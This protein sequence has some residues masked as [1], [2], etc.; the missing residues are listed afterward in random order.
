MNAAALRRRSQEGMSQEQL[1]QGICLVI[2]GALGVRDVRY[3]AKKNVYVMSG[4]R[5]LTRTLSSQ[6]LVSFLHATCPKEDPWTLRSY[7]ENSDHWDGWESVLTLGM[8]C[9]GYKMAEETNIVPVPSS[10]LP[11]RSWSAAKR[12]WVAA[13]PRPQ[14]RLCDAP[15][16]Q[17]G[18]ASGPVRLEV[19][20]GVPPLFL[21]HGVSR[22]DL[23]SVE[24]CGGLLWPSWALSWR[25]P[26]TYGD[27][28]F[29]ADAMVIPQNIKPT[30]AHDKNIYVA[31]TDIW[32]PTARD[33]ERREKA[34]M[35]EQSGDYLWW[36]GEREPED[37]GWGRRGLQ[38]DLVSDLGTGD[39]VGAWADLHGDYS[40]TDRISSRRQLVRRMKRLLE[41][42]ADPEDPYAYPDRDHERPSDAPYPYAE[43]KVTGPVR[44]GD[45]PLVV[46]PRRNRALV[47]GILR[48]CEFM[49]SRLE[50]PW[51]GPLHAQAS[52]EDR[53]AFA[54]MVTEAILWWTQDPCF[55]GNVGPA[56]RVRD[57][58]KSS[59]DAT[60]QWSWARRI[61]SVWTRGFCGDMAPS[62]A[63][64]RR[65]SAPMRRA[66]QRK[67]ERPDRAAL[68][69]SSALAEIASSTDGEE[70]LQV[71]VGG[72]KLEEFPVSAAD[73]R[74]ANA[75]GWFARPVRAGDRVTMID[76]T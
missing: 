5:A 51:E 74:I 18:S 56:L 23:R 17:F 64:I 50:I 16:V 42:Y 57:S 44:L 49:G 39:I 27:V 11:F 71:L 32:S 61:R 38:N 6:R 76:R 65:M 47:D 9:L 45:I 30:G 63:Q 28:V 7:L 59:Y 68:E 29:V 67:L 25:V 14:V 15:P 20:D 60:A 62:A 70:V 55:R 21:T 34:M 58:W 35:W 13:G 12:K 4:P 33:L 69:L 52:D 24:K 22:S 31:G 54:R 36:A 1:L 46:Y 41:V 53:R 72:A 40:I 73:A 8:H 3:D 66:V 37:G 48:R 26:P 43:V 75:L 2:K 10:S 19:A